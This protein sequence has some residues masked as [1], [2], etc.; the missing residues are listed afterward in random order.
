MMMIFSGSF[1]LE[2]NTMEMIVRRKC[3]Y[4]DCPLKPSTKD[5]NMVM[6]MIADL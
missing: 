1:L 2:Y 4:D 5:V 3:T 6:M